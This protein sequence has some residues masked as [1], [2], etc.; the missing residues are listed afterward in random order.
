MSD[1]LDGLF[2]GMGFIAVRVKDFER[3]V[4]GGG[5]VGS[6]VCSGGVR[7]DGGFLTEFLGKGRI[8]RGYLD[9]PCLAQFPTQNQGPCGRSFLYAELYYRIDGFFTLAV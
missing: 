6:V 1:V 2:F 8:G 4:V 7:S 3:K 9:I 5:Q